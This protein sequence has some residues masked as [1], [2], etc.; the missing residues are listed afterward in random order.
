MTST[1]IDHPQAILIVDDEPLVRLE[2]RGVV[3]Q[4]GYTAMEASSTAEALTL[5]DS[6]AEVVAGLITDISMPG[7]RSGIILA[8]HVGFV[9]PHIDII[10]VSGARRPMAGELPPKAEFLPKPTLPTRL[11]AAIQR[12]RKRSEIPASFNQN[13]Q[14][15]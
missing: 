12:L 6:D 4:C 2:L 14:V 13:G 8:N 7:S 3:E 9:W 1:S 10:V 5:L 15:T 11:L